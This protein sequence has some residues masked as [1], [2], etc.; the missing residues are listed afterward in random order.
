MFDSIVDA[1]GNTPLVSLDRITRDADGRILAKL[2]MLN[3]GFSKKDRAAR[4]IIFE[5]RKSGDLQDGQ[6]VVEL[7][8]GNMGT[9][10]AIVCSVLGHSLLN[11]AVR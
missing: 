4:Q 1:I 10:L 2:E 5:A 9:G 6:T 7:T 11:A 8:S 3:P